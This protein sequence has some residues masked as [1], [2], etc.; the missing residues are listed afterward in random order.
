MVKG[1]QFAA[2]DALIA[3]EDLRIASDHDYQDMVVLLRDIV[4]SAVPTVPLPAA[5]WLLGSVLAGLGV[6][7]RRR[8]GV[9]AAA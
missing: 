8:K 4:P 5:V 3:W 2:S 1:T 6:V 7:G 9:P